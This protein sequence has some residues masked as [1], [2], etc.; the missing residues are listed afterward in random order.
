M[1]FD[2]PPPPDEDLPPDVE[3]EPDWKVYEKAI[4][5]VEESFQN[6]RVTRNHKVKGRRSGEERQVDV[7]LE[8]EIGDNHTVTVAIECRR[9]DRPVSIKDIDAF[10]GFLDDVGANKGVMISHSGYTKGARQR[11]AGAGIEVKMLM[12]TVE[13]AEEFDLEEFVRDSC[14]VS[15]DCFGTISWHFSDGKSEAGHCTNCG[16]FHIRCGD[17]GSVDWY[18]EL[19]IEK[20]LS[21]GMGWRLIK[22]KGMTCGIKEIPAEDEDVEVEEGM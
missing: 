20:C 22:E 16:S 12:L 11:A 9:Y 13:E 15:N 8:T 14:Q 5:H 3:P 10:A 6:C 18:N 21:C 17:C 4:A 1:N 7:W 2:P 19:A